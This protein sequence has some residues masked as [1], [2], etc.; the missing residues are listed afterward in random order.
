MAAALVQALLVWI[1]LLVV[2]TTP[3]ALTAAILTTRSHALPIEP[4]SGPLFGYPVQTPLSA[5]WMP[6]RSAAGA[7]H[8]R[9]K[10]EPL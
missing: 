3:A 8:P 4:Y 5:H 2:G 10:A 9:Q 7:H 6:P 1:G